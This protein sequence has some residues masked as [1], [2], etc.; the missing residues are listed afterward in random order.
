MEAE[1]R[2]PDDSAPRGAQLTVAIPGLNT[3]LDLALGADPRGVAIDQQLGEHLGMDGGL[4]A[5]GVAIAVDEG[6]E[7][8]GL[9]DDLGDEVGEVI[10]GEPVVQ[11]RGEEKVLLGIV[12]SKD[13]G[14]LVRSRHA[15]G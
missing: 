15:R 7:V 8:E 4:A 9:L 13:R 10:L 2:E 14:M 11:V 5:L 12:A 1:G 3:Y 6:G